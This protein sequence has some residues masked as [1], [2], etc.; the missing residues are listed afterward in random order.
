MPVSTIK[1]HVFPNGCKLIYEK[2]NTDLPIAAVHAFIRVGSI[3][4][5]SQQYGASHFIEHMCFKGTHKYKNAKSIFVEYDKIG[6]AFNAYTEKDHTCFTVK[7]ADE[8]L[9]NCIDTLADIMLD[10]VFK[11]KEYVLE[12]PVLM[13]EMI[14]AAD[15]PDTILNNAVDKMLYS[16]TPYERPV[17]DVEYH[18]DAKKASSISTIIDYYH[19]HYHPANMAISVVSRLPFETV[20]RIIQRTYGFRNREPVSDQINPNSKPVSDQINPNSRIRASNIPLYS[21]QI[22]NRDIQYHLS[23]KPGMDSAH[24]V[25]GFQTC[26]HRGGNSDSGSHSDNNALDILAQILGG[27]MSG[28]MFM[29]LR[30][31]NGLTYT[32]GADTDYCPV[33]GEFSLFATVDHRKLFKNGSKAGVLPLLVGLLQGLHDRGVTKEEVE[34]AKGYIKG[35]RLMKREK[36]EHTAEYN[37]KQWLLYPEEELVPY[38]QIFEK[39]YKGITVGDV[40]RVIRKYLT[41][42]RLCVGIIGSHPIRLENVVS[43]FRNLCMKK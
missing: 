14:R 27:S 8:Y 17:D 26:G 43:V 40:N 20:K 16:G 38:S 29:L 34:L 30:E 9:D 22:S 19:T 35:A 31:A 36:I 11:K 24:I 28:R 41:R 42:E 33:G 23:R 4:E 3:D 6:A 5:S 39:R 37:G 7:C 18:K 13:E 2:S 12:T 25:L 32:S 15:D 1:K 21:V 10:S